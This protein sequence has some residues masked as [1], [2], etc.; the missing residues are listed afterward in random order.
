[1]ARRSEA[2]IDAG[3]GRIYDAMEAC[4]DRGLRQQ[5]CLPGG[6]KVRRRARQVLETIA[7]RTDERVTDPIAAMDFINVWALAVN[8]ENAAVAGW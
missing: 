3:L 7:R 1:M 6:L 8:E 5:G 2:E 4:I